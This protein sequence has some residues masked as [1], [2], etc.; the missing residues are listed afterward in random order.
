[1]ILF[2]QSQTK[3]ALV[4]SESER[5][6]LSNKLLIEDLQELVRLTSHVRSENTALMLGIDSLKVGDACDCR[7]TG[8]RALQLGDR[9][10]G[11]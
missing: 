6:A 1:M 2:R 3:T 9:R 4:V 10:V 8:E 5:D 7:V 11:E